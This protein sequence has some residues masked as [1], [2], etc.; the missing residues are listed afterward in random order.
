VASTPRH[1]GYHRFTLNHEILN[2]VGGQAVTWLDFEFTAKNK[3]FERDRELT[4]LEFID[5]P[6]VQQLWRGYWPQTG[7][8]PNWDAVGKITLGNQEG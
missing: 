4:G 1:L 7:S 6:V 3:P 2:A 8:P 5:S